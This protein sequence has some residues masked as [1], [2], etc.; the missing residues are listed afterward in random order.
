MFLYTNLCL[1]TLDQIN[2]VLG[3]H[4]PLRRLLLNHYR[5]SRGHRASDD[6]DDEYVS[7]YGGFSRRRRPKVTG[8]KFP[9]VPSEQGKTLM[10]SGMYG[11]NENFV[12]RRR[13]RK[14][15][16]SERLLWRKLGLDARGSSRRANRY[17]AQVC[18]LETPKYAA[19][20]HAGV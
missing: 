19:S 16:V 20:Y 17:I 7:G 14:N 15:N 5:G 3:S 18:A 8:D 1:V 6:D 2:A 9:K 10:N 4:G 11:Y 13:R 12:D